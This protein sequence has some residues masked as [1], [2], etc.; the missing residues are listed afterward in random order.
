VRGLEKKLFL[1]CMAGLVLRLI[2]LR[3]GLPHVYNPDEVAI[4][5]RALSFGTGTLN[6]HNFLY[7][8]FYFYVLFGWVASYLGLVWLTGGVHSVSE[9]KGLYLSDP[10]GIYTAGR[11]LG[12]L[13]G[14]AT[15]AA[16]YQLG[17][18]LADSHVAFAAATFVAVSPLHVRDSHYVKHDVAATL[19]VV[20]AYIAMA[21]SFLDSNDSRTQRRRIAIAAAA[22]GVAFSIHYY[23]VFLA[24]PLL[25]AAAVSARP[26][27]IRRVIENCVLVTL[28]SGGVF[29]LLSPFIALDPVTAWR[30][31]TA[32]RE[33]VVDRA[34][35]A[36]PF[37]PAA[38]YSDM[39]FRD[40]VGMPV[41]L[42]AAIGIVAML[43][44]RPAVGLFLLS[45]PAAF[46]LF[47]TNTF[48]ASRYLNPVVPFVALFAAGG[49]SAI[50]TALSSRRHPFWFWALTAAAAAPALFQSVRT[51]LF[52]RR[53]DT[54][55]IALS[56][57]ASMVPPGAGVAIQPYS[58]PLEPTRESLVRALE[59]N[60]GSAAAPSPKFALQLSQKPWPSPSYNLVYLGRGLDA[61]KVY[62]D[63]GEL[64]GDAGLRALRQ[65]SVAYVVVKRYNRS[66]P[67][68][69]PFLDA[70]ARE[71]RM[72]AAVSPFRPDTREGNATE[73]EPFLHN[74]DARIS[75]VLERPGPA[76]EIW[77]IDGPRQ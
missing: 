11:L 44:S 24:I 56:E 20:L 22:C 46:F 54:R 42:L 6:P 51:D 77:Q 12:A 40:A 1:L 61:E 9:L 34:V 67:E 10:S 52:I 30:D 68:T 17:R 41:A 4:M 2:G 13:A 45:F 48:P 3:Y 21:P 14:T 26:S 16:I 70:L 28:I 36:G 63:Y 23:C 43:R 53:T 57:I 65:L 66:D 25:A 8:T 7:P 74:T 18:R 19:A 55:T 29:L 47:I 50:V 64:G 37:A 59:Q 69:L 33:I 58:V 76:L 73:R 75:A 15:I 72:V 27:G 71:A 39:L 62:V 31:I 35:E 49:A 38:R 5:T 32:N 60:L